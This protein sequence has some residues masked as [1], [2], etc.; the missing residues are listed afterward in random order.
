M[1]PCITQDAVRYQ[2]K[3]HGK[4]SNIV[5]LSHLSRRDHVFPSVLAPASM[6]QR[7]RTRLPLPFDLSANL[8]FERGHQPEA[9]HLVPERSP[10]QLDPPSTVS[11]SIDSF[12][13]KEACYLAAYL[14]AELMARS[15]LLANT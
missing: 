12:A 1:L 3:K 4:K 7:A 6:T 13:R 15:R 8:K 10:A 9:V 5:A 11:I 2:Y 14:V